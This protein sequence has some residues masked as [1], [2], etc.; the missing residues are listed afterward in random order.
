MFAI[1]V[2][3]ISGCRFIPSPFVLVTCFWAPDTTAVKLG[4]LKQTGMIRPC[5]DRVCPD[6][7]AP[8]TGQRSQGV[9]AVGLDTSPQ[10]S[11]DACHVRRALYGLWD[12]PYC[13][14]CFTLPG[15]RKSRLGS[16]MKAKSAV[17]APP[18]KLK[19][20]IRHSPLRKTDMEPESRALDN[21]LTAVLL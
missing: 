21:Y 4:T 13:T 12:P 2:L 7:V 19:A 3:G 18:N 10:L 1:W 16:R 5:N 6:R 15:K 17:R 14:G 9:M 8:T 11:W 20:G